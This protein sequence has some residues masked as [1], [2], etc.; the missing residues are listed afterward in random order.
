MRG[1]GAQSL[2]GSSTLSLP[3]AE[4][5]ACAGYS[6]TTHFPTRA[7]GGAVPADLNYLTLSGRLVR[8]PALSVLPSEHTVCDML[9]ER[10]S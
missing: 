6:R 1:V 4:F 2:A 9:V 3:L 8:D 5:V 10:G 7:Q